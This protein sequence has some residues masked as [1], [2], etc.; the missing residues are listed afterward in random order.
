[1]NIKLHARLTAYS[2]V[3]PNNGLPNPSDAEDRSILGVHDGKYV[4]FNDVDKTQIDSLF[5]NSN[6]EGQKSNMIDDLFK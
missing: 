6:T 1:M 5:D 4:F 3:N 2:R